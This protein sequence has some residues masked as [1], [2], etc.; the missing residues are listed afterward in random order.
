VT[1][2]TVTERRTGATPVHAEVDVLVVGGGPAGLAAA[3]SA[4]R[5]G[6]RTCWWSVTASWAAW[7]RPAA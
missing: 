5:G 4:A 2:P 3:V 6:A 1:A 7:A